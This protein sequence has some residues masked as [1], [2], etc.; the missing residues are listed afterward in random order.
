M[1]KILKIAAG[2]LASASVL[3][4][5]APV[6]GE[7]IA[8]LPPSFPIRAARSAIGLEMPYEE[9]SFP[10]SDGLI[11]RGWFIPAPQADAPAIVYAPATRHDQRSGLSLVPEFHAADY[12]V[13]LFSYRGHGRSDGR[14]G[15]FTYGSAESQD[16]DAAVRFLSEARGIRRVGV[17][18]HSAGAVAAIL[19]AA[20]NPRIGAVTAVAP[21]TCI[22]EV[23]NANRPPFVPPLLLNWALWVAEK[24]NG[25]DR[26][27]ICPIDVIDQIAPRP[28]LV[29]HGTAD[30]RISPEQVVRLFA[31]AKQPKF[32]WFVKGATHSSVRSPALD[33][34]A[35]EVIDFFDA[36][37]KRQGQI[38]RSDP[39]PLNPSIIQF[40]GVESS[41]G[42]P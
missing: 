19:S 12:H 15:F 17:I 35:P 13:L 30:Q 33:Q 1:L 25:F 2:V 27:D 39:R 4:L 6:V 20:R 5:V 38:A 40:P 3:T 18:G 11:L 28:L 29:I 36:A 41:A 10:T 14:R 22:T 16:L 7:M 31:A 42:Q 34:L 21:F 24:R 37:L 8:T 26:D 9:V 32:L 23:W